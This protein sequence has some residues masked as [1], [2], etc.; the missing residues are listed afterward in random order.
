ML[1]FPAAVSFVF[2]WLMFFFASGGLDCELK[3]DSSPEREHCHSYDIGG[4]PE[5]EG[6]KKRKRKP[7]RP[8]Q[9]SRLSV[10]IW[11]P[12]SHPLCLPLPQVLGVS[13]CVSVGGRWV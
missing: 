10:L 9:R 7:Y 1:P 8:G 6:N 2:C 12:V 13:W 3:S 4:E 11:V 5:A